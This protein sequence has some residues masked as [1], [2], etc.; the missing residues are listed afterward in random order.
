MVKIHIRQH[1]AES[2]R[3]EFGKKEKGPNRTL[4][5]AK[6]DE[7]KLEAAPKEDRA[8]IIAAM[9]DEKKKAEQEAKAQQKAEEEKKQKEQL[10]SKL[11]VRRHYGGYPMIFEHPPNT[12]YGPNRSS[13]AEP[14]LTDKE[15]QERAQKDKQRDLRMHF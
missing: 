6:A 10:L 8:G 3:V 1:G 11:H 14:D 2:W 9:R 5:E 12:K 15:L 4:E 7:A 13:A